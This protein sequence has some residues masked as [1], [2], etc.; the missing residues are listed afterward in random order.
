LIWGAG[1]V[2]FALTAFTLLTI[3]V[4]TSLCTAAPKAEPCAIVGT[5]VLAPGSTEENV[6]SVRRS[7]R[8][9]GFGAVCLGILC[10][11][12]TLRRPADDAELEAALHRR[13]H[14]LRSQGFPVPPR[15]ARYPALVALGGLVLGASILAG[16][17]SALY[18][19]TKSAE[20]DDFGAYVVRGIMVA[21]TLVAL[22]R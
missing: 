3:D 8:L 15:P 2:W 19:G 13:N 10:L 20:F 6:L 21:V 11:V 14:R 22:S 5:L 17:F 18:Y 7:F 4:G 1:L 16:I 9:A 12:R